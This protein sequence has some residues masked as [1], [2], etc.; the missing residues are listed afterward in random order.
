MIIKAIH[1]RQWLHASLFACGFAFTATVSAQ[2][3]DFGSCVRIEDLSARLACYDR[4]AGRAP[5]TATPAPAPAAPPVSLVPPPSPLPVLP[6][7]GARA[8]PA[9]P[10]PTLAAPPAMPRDPVSEFGA[11]AKGPDPLTAKQT[12]VEPQE[13]KQIEARVTAVRT[14]PEGQQVLTLDNGQVWTQTE[15]RRDPHFEVGDVVI[16]KR[17][18]LGSFLLTLQKGSASTRVQRIS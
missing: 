1:R 11:N 17:G 7:P 2:T 3:L 4:A 15:T 9:L 16:I 12:K 13:V 5:S 14:R 10:P 18:L 6:S 8:Q